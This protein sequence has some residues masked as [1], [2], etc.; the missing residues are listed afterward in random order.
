MAL[1]VTKY[2]H[3]YIYILTDKRLRISRL[4]AAEVFHTTHMY[5][6]GEINCASCYRVERAGF[7]L[8][9][10]KA[11]IGVAQYGYSSTST[12]AYL[13]LFLPSPY[14]QV[15]R[16]SQIYD[17]QMRHEYSVSFARS[18]MCRP[19][20]LL[21]LLSHLARLFH[22]SHQQQTT[23]ELD[24]KDRAESYLKCILQP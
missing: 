16:H 21:S 2:I 17:T 24:L 5:G 23:S 10:V 12:L 15:C 13:L 18:A 22:L 6:L 14:S 4:I 7:K 19:V 11:T 1:Y 3:E 8:L 20:S 9:Q